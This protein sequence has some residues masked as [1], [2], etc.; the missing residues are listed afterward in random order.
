VGGHDADCDTE[1]MSA[2]TPTISVPVNDLR[3]FAAI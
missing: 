2:S 3:M 1:P